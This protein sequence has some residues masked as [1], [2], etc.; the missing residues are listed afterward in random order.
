MGRPFLPSIPHTSRSLHNFRYRVAFV[1]LFLAIFQQQHLFHIHR[2]SLAAKYSSTQFSSSTEGLHPGI[3]RPDDEDSQFQDDLIANRASWTVLGE[4]WE[5]KVYTYRDTVIKTFTPGRSPFRNCAPGVPGQKWPTE[6]PASLLLGGIC[7]HVYIDGSK[8]PLNTST[9]TKGF[10]PVKAYFTA[11][12]SPLDSPRWYLAT[13]RLKGGN[14]FNLAH[15]MSEGARAQNFREVDSLYRPAFNRLLGSIESLHNAGYCHDDI[16]PANIF[17]QDDTHWKL[18]DLGNLRHISH[19][20]H[21]SRLWRDNKQLDDCRANDVVRVLKSYLKFV[22]SSVYNKDQFNAAFY[23]GKEPISRLFW[24]TLANS[25]ELSAAELHQRS[26]IE[27]P[28]SS[29]SD[30]YL[31]FP[32]GTPRRTLANVFS[33]R[34]A[35]SREVDHALI[36]RMGEKLARWWAMTWLY[37]VPDLEICGV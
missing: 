27:Y 32:L 8:C 2:Q 31:T 10:L 34:L 26:L 12:S 7:K 15:K 16:K 6:I 20:Y 14:L 29:P 13:P 33:R 24:W 22:Q 37:G 35:L 28:E 5:G 19:P 25:P 17:V 4:G 11:P 9:T 30:D 3:W 23:E 18:G 1:L 21:I 36:T